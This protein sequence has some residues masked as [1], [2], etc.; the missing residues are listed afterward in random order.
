M[1]KR[2]LEEIAAELDALGEKFPRQSVRHVKTGGDYILRGF[3]VNTCTDQV[4][5]L[6]VPCPGFAPTFVRNWEEFCDGR[7]EFVGNGK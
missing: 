3:V 7:F 5:V 1:S 6:Y 2:P 4:D